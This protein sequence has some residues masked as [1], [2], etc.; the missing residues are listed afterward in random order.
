MVPASWSSAARPAPRPRRHSS[1][2]SAA[3]RRS[4]S[5]RRTP[6]RAG[7]RRRGSSCPPPSPRPRRP[8]RRRPSRAGDRCRSRGGWRG[9][10]R[11]RRP[12]RPLPGPCDRRHCS[13]RPSRSRRTGGWSRAARRTWWPGGRARRGEARQG[14]GVV[15]A[16]QVVRRVE[17]LDGD[18]LGVTQFSAAGSP[19]GRTGRRLGPLA[20]AWPGRRTPGDWAL[21]SLGNTTHAETPE[22]M[23][24]CAGRSDAQANRRRHREPAVRA[25]KSIIMNS[26]SHRIVRPDS[27]GG[28]RAAESGDGWRPWQATAGGHG[29]RPLA[30]MA[31]RG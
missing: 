23:G 13:P 14:V 27:P 7:C 1:P 20:P 19:P 8:C 10:K 29:R 18:A 17:R 30:A 16:S 2:G 22:L 15:Q 12:A 3:P 5:W 9:Q 31:G 25:S 26:V 6:Y 4:W 24:H 28:R 21:T 11:R